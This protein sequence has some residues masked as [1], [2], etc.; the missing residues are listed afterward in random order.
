M[1]NLNPNSTGYFHSYE[2]NTNDLTMAMDYSG[3][4]QPVVRVALASLANDGPAAAL[5]AFG[6]PIAVPIIPII[7]LDGLYGLDP[8]EFETFTFGTGSSTTNGQLIQAQTGTGAYG[9]GVVR[10]N[11][12]ARYR[13]GQGMMARF[14]AMFENPQA[15]V[16]LRAGLFAQEQAL[17]FGYDSAT[18]KF[19]IMVA[20][21]GKAHIE[22]LIVTAGGTGNVTITLNGVA[23][24]V[25]ISS[26]NTTTVAA[27]IAAATFT[28]WTTEQIDN[29][30]RFLSNSLGTLAGAFTVTGTG[31]YTIS[32]VQT[33]VAQTES[34]TYQEDWSVDK[35]D[36]TGVSGITMDWSKLNVFQID[37]RWLG[38]GELRWAVENPDTGDLMFVHHSHYANRQ[39]QVHI[40]NPCFKIGYVAANLSADTKTNARCAGASMMVAIEGFQNDNAFTTGWP[41]GEKT[42]LGATT[43]TAHQIISYKNRLIYKDKVNLRLMK[44]RSLS[45]SFQGNDPATVFLFLDADKDT[46]HQWQRINTWS[47]VAYDVAAG[48]ITIANYKPVACFTLPINGSDTFNLENLDLSVPP[49]SRLCIGMQSGQVMSGVRAS[50]NWVEV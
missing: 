13:P 26:T 47:S 5:S 37:F 21:G 30:V 45:V 16:T 23:T 7:Q 12:V 40:D 48:S 49:G 33:G 39:T 42:S 35:L 50:M 20:N 9:Y 46:I 43:T 38:I 15:G 10:S 24:V 3:Q 25:A 29:E 4:G 22:K 27:Q 2:P 11:R 14:T 34:W 32:A 17:Q 36:G 31:T 19:G 41:S 8:Y 1:A 18:N 44:L 28:G 6:E